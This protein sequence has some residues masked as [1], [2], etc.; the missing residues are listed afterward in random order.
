M[1]GYFN[2]RILH[3]GPPR[4]MA[5]LREG[6]VLELTYPTIRDVAEKQHFLI[7]RQKSMRQ[8]SIFVYLSTLA[9][10]DSLVLY[11]GLLR[12]WLGE[13]TGSDIRDESRWLCKVIVALGYTCS[14]VSVWLI[15]AVTVERYIV[16]CHPLRAPTFCQDTRARKIVAAILL[17]FS[18]VNVHL[19]FS[20]DLEPVRSETMAGTGSAASVAADDKISPGDG[21]GGE[22]VRYKC[23]AVPGYQLVVSFVWPWVDALLYGFG[24]FLLI[25]IFNC[26]ILYKICRASQSRV[27]LLNGRDPRST[28]PVIDPSSLRM[29][30][31]LL[32]VSFTFLLTTLP[33][34]VSSILASAYINRAG[35]SDQTKAKGILFG[36]LATLL[37]YL[38]HSVNFLLYCATGRKFRDVVRR[39]ACSIF[40]RRDATPALDHSNHLFCSRKGGARY[41]DVQRSSNSQES[42][43]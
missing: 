1:K 40:R 32:S 21:G 35:S 41:N 9:V 34:N 29:T 17:V 18:L 8:Q 33:M 30:V 43:V 25:I 31:M 24:P 6:S 11:I 22:V 27:K 16:V 42:Q 23:G 38:N 4:F 37:M 20:T 39:L 5:L 28:L 14:D 36:T 13:L 15:V 3:P 10:F 2:Q 19:L 7:L 26:F 12:L